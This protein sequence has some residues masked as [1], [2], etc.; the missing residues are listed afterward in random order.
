MNNINKDSVTVDI[1]QNLKRGFCRCQF[2]DGRLKPCAYHDSRASSLIYGIFDEGGC[3]SRP[4]DEPVFHA[5]LCLSKEVTKLISEMGEGVNI[6]GGWYLIKEQRNW[7]YERMKCILSRS[8]GKCSILVSGVAGYAHFYSYLKVIL[9]AAEDTNFDISNLNIDVLDS[10]ITPLLEIATIENYIQFGKHG[11]LRREQ[12]S[13]NILGYELHIPK[14]NMQFIQAI[15]DKIKACCIRL[16]HSDILCLEDYRT[17]LRNNYDVITEHF[18][19]SMVEN[20]E[21]A[22]QNIRQAYSSL[23]RK[24]GHLLIASGISSINYFERL[25]EIHKANGFEANRNEIIKV[26]DP[27]GISR[28]ELQ[29]I[30]LNKSG[31]VALDNCMIDFTFHK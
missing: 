19:I 21:K 24:G 28:D 10:C 9:D 23:M 3:P 1:M 26:W 7:L 27:Y 18:L 4:I 2:I 5:P 15:K 31:M 17:D 22:I 20:M 14:Q 16:I 11:F 13:H 29:Q 8:N 6:A 30:I 12:M 25:L